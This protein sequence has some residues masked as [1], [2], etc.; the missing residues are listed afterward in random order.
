MPLDFDFSRS[1]VP[2]KPVRPSDFNS[3][4][5]IEKEW[6]P[7]WIFGEN[8][9]AEGGGGGAYLG[10][11]S[12]N[13]EVFGLDVERE[14]SQMFL[15]NSDVDRFITTFLTLDPVLRVGGTLLT[16]TGERLRQID[17]E[18]FERSEWRLLYNYVTQ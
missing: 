6:T 13:G 14:T 10:V 7:L 3:A 18:A 2:L 1:G 5:V 15:L 8:D 9:Y 16:H 17:S 4:T 12:Q 11:H